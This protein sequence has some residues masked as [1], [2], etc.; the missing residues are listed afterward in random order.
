M[1]R[2]DV[3]PAFQ[4]QCSITLSDNIHW[5][6]RALGVGSR[7]PFRTCCHSPCCH[8]VAAV[9][10]FHL[11]CIMLRIYHMVTGN[12][13]DVHLSGS[14]SDRRGELCL[15]SMQKE[16][17]RHI[18]RLTPCSLESFLRLVC[19]RMWRIASSRSEEDGSN[20]ASMKTI[21]PIDERTGI[22]NVDTPA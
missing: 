15:R 11:N 3:N 18:S 12:Y 21:T 6:G 5:W 20:V 9:P 1:R 4:R 19:L 7:N 22:R 10:R 8:R 2:L 16:T 14:P 13:V 17:S